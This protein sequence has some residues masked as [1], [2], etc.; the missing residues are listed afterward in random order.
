MNTNM[1]SPLLYVSRQCHVT[2]IFDLP[3]Y[4]I[5]SM[6]REAPRGPPGPTFEHPPPPTA[7]IYVCGGRGGDVM[8]TCTS[9]IWSVVRSSKIYLDISPLVRGQIIDDLP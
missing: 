8:T 4:L 2:G 3:E 7:H 5:C 6:G 1:I 9:L